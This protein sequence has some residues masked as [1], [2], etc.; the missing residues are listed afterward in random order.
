METPTPAGWFGAEYCSKRDRNCMD[1]PFHLTSRR[2]EKNRR[3]EEEEE[4]DTL[5]CLKAQRGGGFL[6][7]LV[8]FL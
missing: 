5:Q 1:P 4:L 8:F 2:G 7:V 6:K 3:G